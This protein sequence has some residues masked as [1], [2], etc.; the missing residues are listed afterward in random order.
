[1]FS[2]KITREQDKINRK[3]I[4]HGVEVFGGCCNRGV[5]GVGMEGVLGVVI[6]GYWVLE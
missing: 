4:E 1:M 6:E 5:L 2:L 3:G